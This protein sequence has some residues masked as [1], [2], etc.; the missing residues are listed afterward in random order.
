[1]VESREA[2]EP[3]YSCV[4]AIASLTGNAEEEVVAFGR[5]A[6]DAKQQASELLRQHYGCE[7]Q[8]VLHLLQQAQIEPLAPWCVPEN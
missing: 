3:L 2:E 7:A 5:S 1:M 4:V 6:E 8:Q